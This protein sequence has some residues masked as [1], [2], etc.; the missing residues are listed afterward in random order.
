MRF[1]VEGNF[2]MGRLLITHLLYTIQYPLS[3]A[4]QSSSRNR[5]H[6]LLFF[7]GG[8]GLSVPD[9]DW[10]RESMGE[11]NSTA[12]QL[13]VTHL[14]YT[15][16]DPISTARQSSFRKSFHTLLF[17]FWWTRSKHLWSTLRKRLY[18]WSWIHCRSAIS[19]P[20]LIH[21]SRSDRHSKTVQFPK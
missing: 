9:Q 19:Y 20:S 11:A 10:G 3:A 4:K 6:P 7:F 13:L 2:S 18:E 21:R 16:Q 8:P 17:I 15:V 14:L 1:L 5:F 12:G